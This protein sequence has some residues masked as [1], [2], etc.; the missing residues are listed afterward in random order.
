MRK[1]YF[2]AFVIL[3]LA[4]AAIVQSCDDSSTEPESETLSKFT[5]VL[6]DSVAYGEVF[7]LTVKA[8]GSSGT[9]PLSSFNGYVV[10]TASD[11]T[12]TPD[13]LRLFSGTGTGDVVLSGGGGSQTITAAYGSIV[14]SALVN[15]G[16][17]TGLDGGPQDPANPAIPSFEFIADD[18]GY[19]VGHPDLPGMYLSHNTIMLAF[20]LGTTVEQANAVLSTLNAEIVGGIAGEEGNAPGTLFLRLPTTT[21][22]EVDAVIADLDADAVVEVA[23]RDILVGP[24]ETPRPNDGDPP[25]WTWES[26]PTGGNWGLERIRVPQLW[27]FNDAVEKKMAI[28]VTRQSAASSS[29]R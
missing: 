26:P 15:A 1:R 13:S 9:S 16:Y 24:N 19:S 27:N 25:D 18:D 4:A 6:P 12:V 22:A 17:M 11:G 10:L 2:S 5:I 7:S 21:H 20:G 8:V 14:G 3:A 29:T 28:D 23:V